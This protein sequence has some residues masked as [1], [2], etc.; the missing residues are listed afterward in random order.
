MKTSSRRE[1][2]W[3]NPDEIELGKLSSR[4]RTSH[5]EPLNDRLSIFE[6]IKAS[7][8]DPCVLSN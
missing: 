3:N 5:R 4:C 2:L 6:I 1:R 7:K 8:I